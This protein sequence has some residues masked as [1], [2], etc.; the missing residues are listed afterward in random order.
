MYTAVDFKAVVKQNTR[1]KAQQIEP[2]I[3]QMNPLSGSPSEAR[4]IT[5][6]KSK[7]IDYQIL[8]QNKK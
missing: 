2:V 4:S 5:P 7:I 1:N 8:M 6:S 3:E